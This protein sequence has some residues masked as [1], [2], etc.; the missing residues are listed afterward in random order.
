M[1]TPKIKITPEHTAA[2]ENFLQGTVARSLEIVAYKNGW[3]RTCLS[4]EHF[5]EG[6]DVCTFYTP[7]QRPPARVIVEGCP[8]WIDIPF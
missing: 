2:L 6:D 7:N 1:S 8:A 4:C 3:N 5:R